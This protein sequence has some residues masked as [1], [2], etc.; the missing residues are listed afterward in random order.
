MAELVYAQV[1]EACASNGLRV[2]V[3]PSAPTT[4]ISNPMS[5]E[6]KGPEIKA[7]FFNRDPY[8]VLGLPRTAS[9]QEAKKAKRILLRQFHPD[10]SKHPQAEEFTKRILAA[11]AIILSGP[12]P[13]EVPEPS[14]PR[15]PPPPHREEARSGSEQVEYARDIKAGVQLGP[16]PF[17]RAVQKAK[18]RGVTVEQIRE[19]VKSEEVQRVLKASFRNIVEVHKSKGSVEVRKYIERW[20][21]V[22]IDVSKFTK[23]PEVRAVIEAG[24]K[25][26][27]QL[28]G[29]HGSAEFV[30]F[31]ESWKKA[32]VDLTDFV[33]RPEVKASLNQFVL[34]K[35]ALFAM[36]GTREFLDFVES[37][38]EAG[39]DLGP[40]VNSSEGSSLIER[41]VMIKHQVDSRRSEA[42]LKAW[43]DAGWIPTIKALDY[44]KKK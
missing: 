31:R 18:Q 6:K 8:A 2:R 19:V 30:N 28:F 11:Y 35:I 17:G 24:A 26:K 12:V 5:G 14:G 44:L 42:F 32:G 16:E 25:N 4:L 1:S 37:W 41:H 33:H 38:K 13:E 7:D 22:G 40:V 29:I 39:I 15:P 23:L 9:L 43:A 10:V 34:N 27:I 3:P 36:R 20:K 21:A